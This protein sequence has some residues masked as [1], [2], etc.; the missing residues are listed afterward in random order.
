[1]MAAKCLYC[2]FSF[3]ASADKNQLANPLRKR[4]NAPSKEGK[5]LLV[6]FAAKAFHTQ[7]AACS[8]G[9]QS[10]KSLR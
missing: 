1:M 9:V 7:A 3:F 8:S 10:E 6:M 4:K 5:L 2:L